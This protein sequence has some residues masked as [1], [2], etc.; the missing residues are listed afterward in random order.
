MGDGTQ[1]LKFTVLTDFLAKNLQKKFSK[2]PCRTQFLVQNY[3]KLRFEVLQQEARFPMDKNV[4]MVQAKMKKTK[5]AGKMGFLIMVFQEMPY[6]DLY[7][8]I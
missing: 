8:I 7:G 2:D 3:P 5:K 4:L 6:K 1:F